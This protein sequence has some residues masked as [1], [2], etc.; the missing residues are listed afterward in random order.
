MAI[1]TFKGTTYHTIGDLPAIESQA[2]DFTVTKMD[3]SEIKLRNYFGRK[4]ILNIFPSL[5]TETCASAM[6]HFN[7]IAQ[8]HANVL[9]LCISADLPFAQKRFCSAEH[10]ENVLPVSVFRHPAF[11]KDYG[12]LIADGPFTGLLARAVVVINEHGL[13]IYTQQV[14]DLSEEPDY[15]AITDALKTQ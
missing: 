8:A 12:V 15:P 2:P 6:R 3:L 14:K 4:I 11:G 9:I 13:I 1:I 10:M 7:E 5:D